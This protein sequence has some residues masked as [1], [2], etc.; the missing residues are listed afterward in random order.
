[1]KTLKSILVLAV[2]ISTIISCSKNDEEDELIL[3]V[4]PQYPLKELIFN[5]E[6]EQVYTYIN[7]PFKLEVGYKFK[8]FK[9]GEITALGVRL[10]DNESYRVTLWNADT[11][12][13]LAT[14]QVLSSAGILSFENIEAVQITSGTNYF[15][16]VNTSD[17]YSFKNAESGEIDIFPIESGD[18]LITAYGNYVGVNQILPTTY[19]ESSY[20][21]MVDIK[22]IPNN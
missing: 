14:Q 13:I 2:L 12:E 15:V 11:E 18:V 19:S 8:T 4:D 3:T 5:G 16:S 9:N 22:F 7:K 6:V 17:Y 1:M 20:L 21:G 10:P